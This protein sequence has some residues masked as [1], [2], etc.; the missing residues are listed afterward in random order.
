MHAGSGGGSVPGRWI[1]PT[2]IASQFAGTSLWF[3]GNAVLEDLRQRWDLGDDAV[4]YVT[5]AV[6]LGFIAGTLTF[7]FLAIA[8]RFSP[9]KIFLLCSLAG[10]LANA[11]VIVAAGGP[12]ALVVLRFV[13]GFFLA[14]V[15]PVGMK[16]AAGWYQRDLGRAIGFLV[17]ALVL[18]TAFPHLVRGLGQELPWSTVLLSVSAVAAAGGLLMYLL[19]PDGPHLATGTGFD[20]RALA[21][22]FRSRDFRCSAFGYFGHMWE[23]YTFWAFV[24]MMLTF[25]LASRVDTWNVSLWTCAIIAAGSVG[26]AGGG[27]LSARW[28]SAR[29][30]FVQLAFSGLCCLLSPLVLLAPT[31]LFLTVLL[32]WGVTVVGDS[33]Q[34]SALN[35]ATAPRRLVGSALTIANCIGFSITV[36]SIQLT[37]VVTEQLG[38]SVAF[39]PLAIGPALGLLALAPLARAGRDERDGG[40]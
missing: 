32:L 36:V 25:H 2:I 39:V 12:T 6:Q 26:C 33:P 16:I 24:P 31:P 8:D 27:L 3:A 37:T 1:L 21:T 22:I 5:S 35:A 7:A 23:L 40:G 20:P 10:A 30:A 29:V 28:G 13:T 9:R 11:A 34:F 14:G 19:V 17:G 38:V 18:G 4:G 15:Y